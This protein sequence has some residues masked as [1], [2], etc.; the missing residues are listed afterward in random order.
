VFAKLTN[1]A[2]LTFNL[3]NEG[4]L[5]INSGNAAKIHPRPDMSFVRTI[6]EGKETIYLPGSSIKGVFRSR[7]EQVMRML[8]ERVCDTFDSNGG[9]TCN[10]KIEAIEKGFESDNRGRKGRGHLNGTERYENICEA[11]KLFGTLALGGRISFADAYP[12]S[13]CKLGMRHGVGIDRITGAAHQGALY[14]IE[15]LED[16]TF[17]VKCKLTNFKLY[18]LRTVLWI[19]QDIDDGLVTFGMGGSRGNGQMRLADKEDGVN[20]EYRKYASGAPSLQGDKK[21]PM[22]CEEIVG[23]A[24]LENILK[25]LKI[26]TKEDLLKAIKSA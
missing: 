5:L 6:R 3:R 23:L 14:D 19:L 22:F 25:E 15:T 2:L 11:C 9:R 10:K 20:L 17:S 21:E 7:Y 8:G 18:Q 1:E 13:E 4:P 12:V 24:G 26:N 16:G